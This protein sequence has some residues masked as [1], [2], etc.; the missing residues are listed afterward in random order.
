MASIDRHSIR[1]EPE[2][3]S[4][5]DTTGGWHPGLDS[6]D[7]ARL[8]QARKDKSAIVEE[9]PTEK[10]GLGWYSV[11]CLLLNRMIGTHCCP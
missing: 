4:D 5:P 10:A 2:S 1:S 9:I 11:S 6:R 8:A 3:D 7:E